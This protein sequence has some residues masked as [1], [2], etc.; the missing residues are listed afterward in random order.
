MN[1]IEEDV[2]KMAEE[3]M[4]FE[5]E[6]NDG[7]TLCKFCERGEDVEFITKNKKRIRIYKIIH[8]LDCPVLIAKDVLVKSEVK[9]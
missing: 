7:R 6:D 1:F 2:I 5:T 8:K 3:I 9:K 4:N